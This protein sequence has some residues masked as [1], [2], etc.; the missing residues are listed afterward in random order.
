MRGIYKG[1]GGGRE[2]DLSRIQCYLYKILLKYII[3]LGGCSSI[4]KLHCA[5]WKGG[6]DWGG[7]G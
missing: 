3:R 2:L 7:G 5:K 6:G 1:G 4:E